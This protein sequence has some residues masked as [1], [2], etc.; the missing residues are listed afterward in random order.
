MGHL[1]IVGHLTFI[2][3]FC[4]KLAN[5]IADPHREHPFDFQAANRNADSNEG[6]RST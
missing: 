2:C 3:P 1:T 4:N 6:H 5:Q